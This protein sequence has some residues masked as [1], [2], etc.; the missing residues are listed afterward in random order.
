M[1]PR[2]VIIGTYHREHHLLQRLFRELE[3]TGCR[4]LA[5][6]SID[7]ADTQPPIVRTST[8]QDLSLGDLEAWHLRAIRDADFIWL[9]A[10]GGHVGTSSSFELGYAT[11]LNKPVFGYDLP[12]DEMLASRVYVAQ[13]VFEALEIVFPNG[14]ATTLDGVSGMPQA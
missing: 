6:I 1:R 2:V 8:E 11:A 14:K 3:T 9:F 7:F 5:P 12:F 10:P 4:I 13:S